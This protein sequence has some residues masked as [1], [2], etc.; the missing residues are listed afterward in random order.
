MAKKT[1]R[2]KQSDEKITSSTTEKKE[3]AKRKQLTADEQ[4]ESDKQ[5]VRAQLAEGWD[6]YKQGVWMLVIGA[7]IWYILISLIS[8]YMYIDIY[9]YSLNIHGSHL[10]SLTLSLCVCAC[11][12]RWYGGDAKNLS[13]DEAITM[14]TERAGVV[15]S[16][17]PPLSDLL[18][19]LYGSE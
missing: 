12:N 16:E 8:W 13:K 6:A 5:R 2:T 7:F 15:I 10:I 19:S 1:K 14:F 3:E 18:D 11:V 17:Y 4:F 9:V